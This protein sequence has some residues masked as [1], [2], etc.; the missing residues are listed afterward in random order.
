VTTETT[1]NKANFNTFYI[2]KYAS[3]EPYVFLRKI[4]NGGSHSCIL[5]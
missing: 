1:G 5:S 4:P 3:R 2:S